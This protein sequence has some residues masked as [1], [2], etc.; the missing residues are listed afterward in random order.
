[1]LYYIMELRRPADKK[2]NLSNLFHLQDSIF[3]LIDFNCIA[4]TFLVNNKMILTGN[5]DYRDQ[6]RLRRR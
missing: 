3:L 1:M 4:E 2:H 6:K 5:R